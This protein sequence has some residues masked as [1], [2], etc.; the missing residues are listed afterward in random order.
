M[1]LLSPAEDL[2]ETNRS[3]PKTITDRSFGLRITV[4]ECGVLHTRT[5]TVKEST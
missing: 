5:S 1:E 2:A 4:H 3:G